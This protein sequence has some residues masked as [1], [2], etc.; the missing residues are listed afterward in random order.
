MF[1]KPT[2]NL[3]TKL[4]GISQLLEQ[5]YFGQEC[6]LDLQFLLSLPVDIGWFDVLHV[7]IDGF[8]DLTNPMFPSSLIQQPK[9]VFLLWLALRL[10]C[11]LGI[12]VNLNVFAHL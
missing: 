2:L 4:I 12:V 11:L 10:K 9:V 8:I 5:S 3:V 7:E 6:G 1:F